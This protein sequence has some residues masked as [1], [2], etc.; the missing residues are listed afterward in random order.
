[1]KASFFSLTLIGLPLVA[2][3]ATSFTEDFSGVSLNSNLIVPSNYI[4]GSNSSPLGVAQNN[5]NIR[6]YITTSDTDYNTVDFL[7][8]ITFSMNGPTAAQAV[9]FGIGS[10]IPDGSFFDEPHTSI[11]YRSFPNDFDGGNLA[12]FTSNSSGNHTTVPIGSPGNGLHRARLEKIGNTLTFSLD[13]AYTGV[14]SA[15]YSSVRDIT[16]FPFLDS[17]NSRLFF[18]VQGANATFDDV[19]VTVPEPSSVLL[20]GLAGVMCVTRRRYSVS[21]AH[22]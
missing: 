3:A 17:S 16:T 22:Q 14:F 1:M 10:A 2:N 13:E 7:Y 11:Y 4:F 15:N 8:E 21:H 12:L 18:G 6:R 20:L 19:A 5:T 9:F